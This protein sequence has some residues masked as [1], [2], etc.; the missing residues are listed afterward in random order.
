MSMAARVSQQLG[1]ISAKDCERIDALLRR[2]GLPI[3]APDIDVDE[4][5]AAMQL[6]KKAGSGG[7]RVI[8]LEHIGAATICPAPPVDQLRTIITEHCAS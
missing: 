4:L 1:K 6:D 8:L 7:L 3:R 5:L 2:A